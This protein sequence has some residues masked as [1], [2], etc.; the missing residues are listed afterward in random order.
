MISEIF[1]I[2]IKTLLVYENSDNI[3]LYEKGRNHLT[4]YSI[5]RNKSL[6]VKK[7]NLNH[8]FFFDCTTENL[9]LKTIK[10]FESVFTN[11]KF[12]KVICNNVNFMGMRL[13]MN[14]EMCDFKVCNFTNCIYSSEIFKT[15]KLTDCK[16]TNCSYDKT[17]FSNSEFQN[18]QFNKVILFNSSFYF[19]KF[20]ETIFKNNTYRKCNFVDCTFDNKTYEILKKE[21]TRITRPK[22]I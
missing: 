5:T 20:T 13:L 11:C 19:C 1:F 16:I 17:V 14:I 7:L 2:D 4:N 22:I 15:S 6:N 12:N 9:K 18:C 8:S 3:H 10:S 21:N